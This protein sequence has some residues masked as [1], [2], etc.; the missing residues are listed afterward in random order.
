M[1]PEAIAAAFDAE[2]AAL[3]AVA[4]GLTVTD[5][6]RPSPCPPWTVA[7]L[8]CHVVLGAG[9]VATALAEP[10]PSRSGMIATAAYYRPDERFSVTVNAER[11]DSAVRLAE[12]LGTSAAIS[13][14]LDS[15]CQQTSALLRATPLSRAI[16]TRHGDPMLLTDFARTRVVELGLH[17]LDLAAALDRPPWL[18]ERAA[19]VIEALLLPGGLPAGL[20]ERLG[21]ERSTL[22]AGLT[23][24][25][26][27]P[28]AAKQAL[29]EAGAVRLAL[30]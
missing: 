19:D 4:G 11:I 2:A 21:V 1:T 27:L 15:A 25:A 10:D 29:R 8:L 5:L 14:D 22:I 3:T 7:G 13:A 28:A 6:A 12:R 23:G 26:D 20:R 30:G 18:T 24:R 9:R 16:R 17:G